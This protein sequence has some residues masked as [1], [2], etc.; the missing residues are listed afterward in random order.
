MEIEILRPRLM[1]PEMTARWTALQRSRP[2]LASPFL[3]PH[4]PRAVERALEAPD[5]GVRIAVLRDNGASV[6]FMPVRIDK[7]SAAP[8]GAPLAP[9]EALV[10]EPSVEMDPRALVRALGVG[11]L[12][13]GRMFTQAGPFAPFARSPR[14]AWIAEMSEGWGAYARSRRRDGGALLKRLAELRRHAEREVGPVKATTPSQSKGD[15]AQLFAFNRSR[16]HALGMADGF[17]ARWPARLMRAAFA[18]PGDAFGGALFTLHIGGELA[19]AQ[20]HLTGDGALHAWMVA[21]DARF[22]AFEPSRLLTCDILKWAP[23]AG[24]DRVC[25]SGEDETAAR[26]LATMRVDLAGG[27]VGVRPA[28]TLVR[29]AAFGVREVF[30]RSPLAALTALPVRAMRRYEFAR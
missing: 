20:F 17:E 18:E 29:R 19:A 5:C 7:G 24:Y 21:H 28:A 30:G 23:G 22:E 10:A 26:E 4:W 11:R 1:P 2:E 12:D 15:F 8:A 25:M 27:F 13:F 9:I 16:L 3:S 14:R 6:G